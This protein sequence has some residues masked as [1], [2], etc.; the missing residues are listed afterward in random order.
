M[1]AA[2]ASLII[3]LSRQGIVFIPAL[4]I[5]K[6]ALGLTGLVWAQPAADVLSIVL[7]VILYVITLKKSAK[8]TRNSKML[9]TTA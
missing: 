3:N 7:A 4:F 5:L 9:R 1:G 2:A 8:Q 6:A